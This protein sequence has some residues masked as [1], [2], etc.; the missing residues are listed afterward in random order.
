[1]WEQVASRFEAE[2][3]GDMEVKGKGIIAVF[4]IRPQMTAQVAARSR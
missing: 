1:V 3:L 2:D 4:G